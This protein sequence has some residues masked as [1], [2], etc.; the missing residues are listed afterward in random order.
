MVTDSCFFIGRDFIQVF[1]ISIQDD[2]RDNE[3]LAYQAIRVGFAY[4]LLLW[5][6]GIFFECSQVKSVLLHVSD[7]FVESVITSKGQITESLVM[8]FQMVVDLETLVVLV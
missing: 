6:V 5:F 7:Q 4:L 1:T 8:S 2:L 3:W